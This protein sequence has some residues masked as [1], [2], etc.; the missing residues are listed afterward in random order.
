MKIT[1]NIEGRAILRAALGGLLIWAAL[2][3]LGDMHQTHDSVIGYGLPLGLTL[4][5]TVALCLPWFELICGML[6]VANVWPLAATWWTTVLFGLFVLLTGQAWARGLDI[7]CGC[8]D[9][10]ILG[11]EP[12]SSTGRL[13]EFIGFAVARNLVFLAGAIHLLRGQR[14]AA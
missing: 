11:I 1:L 7:T 5:K 3:K 6:L 2:S 13:L 8:F 14:R 12:E 9:L 10:S 4:S